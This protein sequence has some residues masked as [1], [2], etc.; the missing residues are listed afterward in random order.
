VQS[1][2]AREGRLVAPLL[3]LEGGF[4]LLISGAAREIGS[5]TDDVVGRQRYHGVM[6]TNT[7]HNPSRSLMRAAIPVSAAFVLCAAAVDSSLSPELSRSVLDQARYTIATSQANAEETIAEA[8]S[9][10]RTALNFPTVQVDGPY[11][12]THPALYN[13]FTPFD[14]FFGRSTRI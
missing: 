12:V 14:D 1:R 3:A 9:A 13:Q 8:G 11:P 10:L 2:G 4:A 7:R 5:S 6:T